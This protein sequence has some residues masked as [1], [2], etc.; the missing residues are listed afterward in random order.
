MDSPFKKRASEFIDDPV[1]LLS[2]VSP[3]PVRLFFEG[4][5]ENYFDRLVIVVGTP[6]SGKTT[7][8]RLLELD[9]LTALQRS[10]NKEYRELRALLH[11]CHILDEGEPRYLSYR[12]PSGS[13][14]RDLW[15]LPYSEAVR[16]ALLRSLI[17]AKT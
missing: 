17:Q 4:D 14:L 6:G 9:T 1:A 12:L 3:Q 13:N 7:I 15:E 11:E 2:L 5:A 10:H 8:A 16:G